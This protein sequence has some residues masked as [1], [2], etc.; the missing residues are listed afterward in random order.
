MRR[1]VISKFLFNAASGVHSSV[2]KVGFDRFSSE[3]Q[4]SIHSSSAFWIFCICG[5]RAMDNS[6]TVGGDPDGG[7]NDVAMS[8]WNLN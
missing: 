4:A 6:M 2:S 5:V 7:S 8:T 1:I 3:R